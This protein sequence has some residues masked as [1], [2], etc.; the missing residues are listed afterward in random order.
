M[1]KTLSKSKKKAPA[2]KAVVKKA[3]P[4]KAVMKPTKKPAARRH[5][6]APKGRAGT[7]GGVAANT[8]RDRAIAHV[9]FTHDT[10]N[11]FT[12]GFTREQATAQAPGNP[13]HLIWTLGH[14]T[15]T[16]H[17]FANCVDGKGTK[18]PEGYEKLFNMGTKPTDNPSDY[19]SLEEVTAAF[20]EAVQRVTSAAETLTAETMFAP[21]AQD[22]GGWVTDRYDAVLK[23]AWHNGWHVGQLA[24]L[25]KA[26]GMPAMFG[27]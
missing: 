27:S 14:L 21:P 24:S 11:N 18:P 1:A 26:M 20:G 22:T 13:N 8:I 17:W 16:Y 9:K 2:K 10:L 19:P 5:A 25:R 6:S 12:K 7:G 23:A 4:K 3:A 15:I